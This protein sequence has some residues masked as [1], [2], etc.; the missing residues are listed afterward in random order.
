MPGI[1]PFPL[2]RSTI[3]LPSVESWYSVSVNMI[4]PPQYSPNP[5]VPSNAERQRLRL[6]SV[7]ST[8][9]D[10]KRRPQVPFDSSI[11]RIPFPGVVKALTVDSSSSLYSAQC[12]PVAEAHA[13]TLDFVWPRLLSVARRAAA[14]PTAAT[15]T[16]AADPKA[17]D[18]GISCEDPAAIFSAGCCTTPRSAA[19]LRALCNGTSGVTNVGCTA[20]IAMANQIHKTRQK[21]LKCAL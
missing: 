11:A 7:F 3:F 12:A 15:A 1:T 4:A 20:L 13:V 16:R 5:L 6:S 17:E 8:P 10:C 19:R 21:C 18:C 2:A 14:T 9:M